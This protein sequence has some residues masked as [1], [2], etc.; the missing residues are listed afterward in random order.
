MPFRF[1]SSDATAVLP[2]NSA[3]GVDLFKLAL[4]GASRPGSGLTNLGERG[5][6]HS[7]SLPESEGR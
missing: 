5:F 4:L 3:G 7:S 6:I 1:F 2:S